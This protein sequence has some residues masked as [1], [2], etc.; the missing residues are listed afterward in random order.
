MSVRISFVAVLV[1]L[2]LPA[3]ADVT[4]KARVI[5]GDTIEIA[6]ERVRFHGIDAPEARQTCT[7]GGTEWACGREATF[8]LARFIEFH[9]I[10][11]K[12]EKRDRYGRVI[13][14]CYAGFYD[15]N[16]KMVREGWALAYRRYST[17]YVDEEDEAR[18]ARAGMWRG[19]FVPPWEWRRGKR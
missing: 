19:E 16:A 12:G 2:A 13:A 15:L 4:G 3:H 14:V 7:A 6:G 5:D 8:A 18:H 11:C 1:F 17:D 9:W 10:T